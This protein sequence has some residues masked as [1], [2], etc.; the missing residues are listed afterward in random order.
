[1]TTDGD[2]GDLAHVSERGSHIVVGRLVPNPEKLEKDMVTYRRRRG[3]E[4]EED[5][6]TIY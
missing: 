3:R 5:T 6:A 1:M 4:I 2:A